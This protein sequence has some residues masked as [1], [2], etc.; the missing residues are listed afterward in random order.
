MATLEVTD[1]GERK[2][3]RIWTQTGPTG[4]TWRSIEHNGTAYHEETPDG[5][6]RALEWARQRGYVVRLWLGD[7]KTGQDWG[8]ENDVVGRISRSMGPVRIPLL[9]HNNRSTGGTGIL[10]HCIL[11]ITKAGRTFYEA[12]NYQE[13]T[14]TVV[15]CTT[16]PDHPDYTWSANRNGD[17]W[18]NFRSERQARRYVDFMTG[19]RMGK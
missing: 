1:Q 18:A 5:V 10:D 7:R 9:I 6:W 11:K 17:T 19:R 12:D 4:Y 15:P 16:C 13:A 2:E 3:Q 14:W 8:D